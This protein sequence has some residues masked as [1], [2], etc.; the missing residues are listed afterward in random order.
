[1]LA[2]S[3][4]FV[5]QN[6]CQVTN[7]INLF[8]FYWDYALKYFMVLDTPDKLPIIYSY[9]WANCCRRMVAHKCYESHTR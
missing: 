4:Q 7:Q 1:M 3:D 8:G 6:G 9:I 5:K 2:I